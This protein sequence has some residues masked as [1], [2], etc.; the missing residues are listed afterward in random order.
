MNDFNEMFKK[1]CKNT[2]YRLRGN[3]QLLWKNSLPENIR[4]KCPRLR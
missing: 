3:E 4:R 2:T 1:Y